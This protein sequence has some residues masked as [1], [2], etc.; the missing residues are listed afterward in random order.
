[1]SFHLCYPLY[2][3][4]IQNCNISLLEVNISRAKTKGSRLNSCDIDFR[5][6]P[7]QSILKCIMMSNLI[8]SSNFNNFDA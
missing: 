6:A 5:V 4:E 8:L 2:E 7:N 3:F 1:M